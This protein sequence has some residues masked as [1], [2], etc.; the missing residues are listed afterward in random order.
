MYV[1]S[2]RCH[3]LRINLQKTGENN[4][5]LDRGKKTCDDGGVQDRGEKEDGDDHNDDTDAKT[6]K[7]YV[8]TVCT[9]VRD[10]MCVF[11]T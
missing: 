8:Y 1:Y 7:Y 11:P 4:I 6:R 3:V 5:Y 9:H 10:S 2:C